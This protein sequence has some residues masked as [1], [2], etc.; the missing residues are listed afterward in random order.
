MCLEIEIKKTLEKNSMARCNMQF[1]RF[2]YYLKRAIDIV[3][4]RGFLYL[5]KRI[6]KLLR[7]NLFQTHLIV[8]GYKIQK[9][10]SDLIVVPSSASQKNIIATRFYGMPPE[11]EFKRINKKDSVDIDLLTEIDEWKTS[12]S[13]T[14]KYLSEGLNC[15]V[16]KKKDEIVASGWSTQARSFQDSFLKR[17]FMLAYD[18]AY[19]FR[20]FCVPAHRGRGIISYLTKF[21]IEDLAVNHGKSKCFALVRYNNGKI[22]KALTKIGWKKVGRAGFIEGWGIRFHYLLGSEAFKETRNRF[23]LQKN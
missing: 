4:E 7:I 13:D 20:G 2:F 16:V 3:Q 6:L 11:L 23:F 22:I 21:I 10:A 12:K 19:F 9:S 15:Y 8:L 1:K 14:L 17:E 5:L 18:E